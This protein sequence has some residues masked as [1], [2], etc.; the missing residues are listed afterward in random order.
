MNEQPKFIDIRKMKSPFHLKPWSRLGIT[1]NQYKSAR[2]WKSAKISRQRYENIILNVQQE[3]IE[4]FRREAEP[5]AMMEAVFGK[6][7]GAE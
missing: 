4:D 7:L 6:A 1:K 2:P 3:L 5:N